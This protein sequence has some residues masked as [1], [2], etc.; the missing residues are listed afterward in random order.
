[1]IPPPTT[2]VLDAG[3]TTTRSCCRR[4]RAASARARGRRRP[5]RARSRGPAASFSAVAAAVERLASAPLVSRSASSWCI[6]WFPFVRFGIVDATCAFARKLISLSMN[7]C[8]FTF[9]PYASHMNACWRNGSSPPA[10]WLPCTI[11]VGCLRLEHLA[12]LAAS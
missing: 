7:A 4:R 5:R 6:I 1:M 8:R 10:S 3:F 2:I 9:S 11:D 12:E